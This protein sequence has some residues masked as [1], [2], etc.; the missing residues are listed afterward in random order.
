MVFGLCL[1]AVLGLYTADFVSEVEIFGCCLLG[2]DRSRVFCGVVTVS[3]LLCIFYHLFLF[4]VVAV[5]TS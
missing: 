3:F 5:T 1:V 2:D 4:L